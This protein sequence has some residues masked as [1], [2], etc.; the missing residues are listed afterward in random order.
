[1]SE[2]SVKVRGVGPRKRITQQ[3]TMSAEI[4]LARRGR[5]GLA[6]LV[7]ERRLLWLNFGG[8]KYSNIA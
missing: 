7:K 6:L 3:S 5:L 8:F 1:M 4:I 2:R